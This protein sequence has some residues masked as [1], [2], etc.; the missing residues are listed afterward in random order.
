MRASRRWSAVWWFPIALVPC[1]TLGAQEC[2]LGKTNHSCTLT[3]DR[4]SPLAPPTVQMYPGAI[5]TVRVKNPFYFERYFMDYQ[6]GQ[7]TPVPDIGSALLTSL[8]P[9]L[10]KIPQVR[11]G[12]GALKN[13]CA[14][15]LVVNDTAKAVAGDSARLTGCLAQFADDAR[16]IYLALEPSVAPDSH[17]P[18]G[19]V[20]P[21]TNDAIS[22]SLLGLVPQIDVAVG[23]E[24]AISSVVAAAGRDTLE[25]QK[26]AV[27]KLQALTAITDLV[28]KDLFAFRTRICDLR[29]QPNSAKACAGFVAPDSG[30]LDDGKDVQLYPLQDPSPHAAAVTRQVTYALDA[31]NLVQ[32]SRE[33]I[34]LASAK[35]SIATIV[36]IYGDV[37]FE[38]SAG[39]FFSTLPVRTFAITSTIQNATVTNKTVTQ[40]MLYPTAIPFA[41]ANYRLTDALSWTEWPSA[42]YLTLGL[43][44]NPATST[45]DIA[46]GPTISWRGIMVSGLWHLGHDVELTPGLAVGDSLGAAFGGTA[47]TK[48]VWKGAF[49]LGFS[50]RV[51]AL[52]GR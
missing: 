52:V 46:L 16:A 49:G 18:N 47:T 45:A 25:G 33:A 29:H 37:K 34:P 44:V 24:T 19:L 21:P 13:L 26:T 8:S 9:A 15:A 7:V 2:A 20:L 32:N 14:P 42:L 5:L 22:R 43:G 30:E 50:V 10:A 48:T 17:S 23:E 27:A 41:A 12:G 51:P 1:A 40:T 38:A 31:L 39:V 11:G 36:I 4:K 35:R 3:I 28:A 6:S